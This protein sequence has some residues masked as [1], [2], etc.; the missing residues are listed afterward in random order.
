MT[1]EARPGGDAAVRWGRAP[2][3]SMAVAAL[4]A[5]AF[6]FPAAF[7]LTR[8]GLAGGEAWR[9]LTGHLTHH[10]VYHFAMDAVP[11]VALGWLFESRYGARRWSAILAA[12]AVLVSIAFLLFEQELESYRGLSGID[13]AAF[14]AG[15]VA[16]LR[17]RR[18]VALILGALLAAKLVF[19]QVTGAFLMPSTGLGDMGLPVLSSHAA[20]ALAGLAAG[21]TWNHSPRRMQA[22]AMT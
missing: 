2:L 5:L 7:E 21:A 17:S 20:G 12:G 19:E 15:I 16:E 10:S 3:V 1:R 14:A 22:G 4:G 8:T 6:T 13:C 9:L 11:L 18:P